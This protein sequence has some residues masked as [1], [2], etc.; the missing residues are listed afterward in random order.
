MNEMIEMESEIK[1][2]IKIE[3]TASCVVDLAG[4]LKLDPALNRTTAGESS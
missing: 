4:N 1:V 2:K 3:T